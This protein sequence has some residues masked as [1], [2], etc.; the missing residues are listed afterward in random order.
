MEVNTVRM[1]TPY[2][3]ITYNH[4]YKPHLLLTTGIQYFETAHQLN[5]KVIIQITNN[6]QHYQEIINI[7]RQEFYR[8]QS[9]SFP[10]DVALRSQGPWNKYIAMGLAPSLVLKQEHFINR[11]Y[12][13]DPPSPLGSFRRMGCYGRIT[14]GINF[15]QGDWDYGLALTYQHNFI[16]LYKSQ[17]LD[18]YMSNIQLSIIFSHNL[19]IL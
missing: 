8:T 3:G 17:D 6:D 5:G 12:Y 14:G 19:S 7:L 15:Q 18:V 10:L 2:L 4:T 9:I 1:N 16:D 11:N 13:P